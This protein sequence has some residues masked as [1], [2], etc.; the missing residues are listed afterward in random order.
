MAF[1]Q[2]R[3]VWRN[4]DIIPWGEANTHV[5]SHALHYGSGVFEGM[6]CYETVDGPAVFRMEAHLDRLYAS[7]E[8]HGLAIPYNKEEI[9]DAVCAVITR[10][11]FASC[12][13]RPICFY[14]SSS[15]G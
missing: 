8:V 5:S 13:V 9:T 2:T 11:E 6:R 12:Y 10:N 1:D 15:L 3:W 7:A 14:G 4:G